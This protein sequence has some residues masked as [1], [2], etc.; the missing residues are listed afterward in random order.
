MVFVP[1]REDEELDITTFLSDF[2]STLANIVT[3]LLVIEN[4]Q[5]N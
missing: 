2:S 3:I 5:E 1:L 4:I